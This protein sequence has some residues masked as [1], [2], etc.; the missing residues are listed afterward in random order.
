MRAHLLRLQRRHA[1][2]VMALPL[3]GT[4]CLLLFRF[5]PTPLRIA[6]FSSLYLVSMLGVTVGFHRLLTH[7][8]FACP[9]RV[10][11]ILTVM[12]CLAAEGPPIFWVANHRLHHQ[13]SDEPRDP[14]SPRRYGPGALNRLRSF[15]HAHAG[16]MLS[17][18][19]AD[20]LR[21]APDLIKDPTVVAISRCYLPIAVAGV[22]APALLGGLVWGGA[23]GWLDGLLWGGLA[24]IFAVQ[25]VTWSINSLGH[26][27]GARDWATRDDS[28]NNPLVALLALG[29]GWHNNHH[30][31]PTSAAHG[32]R[33]WQLDVSFGLV[34]I[35]RRLGLASQVRLADPQ[36]LNPRPRG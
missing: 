21:H 26:L 12:G 19:P 7:G 1:V 13:H 35:L 10:R 15:W 3:L 8:S 33:W 2:P 30:A 22:V 18:L 16:W 9:R 25:Q 36:R 11:A 23:A 5:H 29:E 17:E 32:W 27:F 14:H 4:L 20:P 6:L 34:R 31:A 28:R 24:R